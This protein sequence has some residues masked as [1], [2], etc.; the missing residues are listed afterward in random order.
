MPPTENS[1][2]GVFVFAVRASSNGSVEVQGET[3]SIKVVE[4]DN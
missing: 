1:N 3:D 4:G 2:V